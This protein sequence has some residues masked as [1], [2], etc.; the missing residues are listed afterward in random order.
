VGTALGG[1]A[2]RFAS[3][4][5]IILCTLIRRVQRIS[6]KSWVL[7]IAAIYLVLAVL[8]TGMMLAF[9][10]FRLLPVGPWHGL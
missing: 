8:Y 7:R 2:R 6:F 3:V 1:S 5:A 9:D 10:Y 4:Q